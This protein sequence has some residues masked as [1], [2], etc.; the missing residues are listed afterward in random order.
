MNNEAGVKRRAI[1][2]DMDGLMVDTE[3]L[4]HQAWNE[5]LRPYGCHL[6][7]D[8]IARMIGSRADVSA[9]FV[10]ETFNL[11]LDPSQIIERRAAI[12]AGIHARGVPP[13]PG[14]D[15]LQ[16]QIAQRGIPWGVATSSP[17]GHAEEIL[18]Q[19]G[20]TPTRGAIAAGDEVAHGKPAPD[21]YL[22]AAERLGVP[23]HACI[24]LEDSRPGSLAARAAGML[25]VVVP[26]ALTKTADFR[27]AHFI[28]ESLH[29]VARRL[30]ELLNA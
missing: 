25:T 22:L 12:Y 19:L 26:N 11:P 28:L 29:A 16:Q 24:A 15:V 30:P 27:H 2:F 10:Q 5:L 14:L 7:D 3:P 18:A 23:P 13:M 6:S 17:R 20:L 1:V 4:S 9:R 21:I 8:L